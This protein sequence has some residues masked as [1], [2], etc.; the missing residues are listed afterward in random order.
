MDPVGAACAADPDCID[1]GPI[2]LL[3]GI[4]H[5]LID[6]DTPDD[7]KFRKTAKGKKQKLVVSF[8]TN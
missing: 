7:V 6:P 1:I 5:G 8:E 3:K 4:R 2:P